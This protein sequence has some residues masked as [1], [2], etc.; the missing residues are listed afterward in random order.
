MSRPQV[1][2]LRLKADGFDGYAVEIFNGEATLRT[3]VGEL[4]FSQWASVG[5]LAA[6]V[7]AVAPYAAKAVEQDKENK[8]LMDKFEQYIATLSPDEAGVFVTALLQAPDREAVAWSLSDLLDV[9]IAEAYVAI[10][11]LEARMRK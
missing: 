10:M 3:P 5:K 8:R 4:H 1:G 7:M 6:F 9:S 11:A 2:T